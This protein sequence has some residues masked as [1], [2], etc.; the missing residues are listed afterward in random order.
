MKDK[1]EE[2]F[3]VVHN[4]ITEIELEAGIEEYV[5]YGTP[6]AKNKVVLT[7]RNLL[8]RCHTY[9]HYKMKKFLGSQ[10]P[11]VL[12]SM[13]RTGTY[14]P[15]ASWIVPH[16]CRG[17]DSVRAAAMWKCMV[18]PFTLMLED[19]C[20]IF[21]YHTNLGSRLRDLG[22][23]RLAADLT[24]SREGAEHLYDIH[25]NEN[26]EVNVSVEGNIIDLTTSQSLNAWNSIES[27]KLDVLCPNVESGW[28]SI[29]SPNL[30]D[31]LPQYIAVYVGNHDSENHLSF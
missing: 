27:Q 10:L 26:E 14:V 15:D 11:G 21:F 13:L 2:H 1:G 7:S 9:A 30:V 19:V 3:D 6:I 25:D 18:S 17:M 4:N 5:K 16:T 28:D 31:E 8:E 22:C 23:Q 24:A 29:Q 12:L 20:Q